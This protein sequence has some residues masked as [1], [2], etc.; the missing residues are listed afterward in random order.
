M[1][2]IENWVK[3]T[4]DGCPEKDEVLVERVP[5]P[6]EAL[7]FTHIEDMARSINQEA[8]TGRRDAKIKDFRRR[9][10]GLD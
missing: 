1:V 4:F 2:D 3:C 9:V 10:M 5:A 6:R 7:H 8:S